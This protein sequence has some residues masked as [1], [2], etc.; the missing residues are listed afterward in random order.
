MP[1]KD[2]EVLKEYQKKYR[3]EHREKAHN[4]IINYRLENRDKLLEK[5]LAYH[6]KNS[7]YRNKKIAEW[8]KSHPEATAK[9]QDKWNKSHPEMAAIRRNR[10][11][12]LEYKS[13]GIFTSEEWIKKINEY[14]HRCAY[15]G[16]KFEKLTQDHVI[17]FSKGGINDATNIVPACKSC[18][19]SKGTKSLSE[20]MQKRVN[21][22]PIFNI[23][24]IK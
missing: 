8:H 22:F 21:L 7:A 24:V 20:F 18:N 13:G 19:S 3:A 6:I 4:Y 12:A 9:A 17:P 14:D 16:I 2:K 23:A 11:R 5:E 15:C 1:Y 10:R